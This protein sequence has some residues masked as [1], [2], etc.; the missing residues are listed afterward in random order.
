MGWIVWNMHILFMLAGGTVVAYDG[1]PFHPAG[2]MWDVMEK[3]KVSLWGASPR[4]IQTLSKDGFKPAQGRDLSS[5]KQL[6]TTGAPVTNDVYDFCQREVGL[7][8]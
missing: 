7:P 6:Y 3:Y 5:L 2:S 1:S 8:V 4:Y